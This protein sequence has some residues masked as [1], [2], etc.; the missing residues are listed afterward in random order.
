[1]VYF[2]VEGEYVVLEAGED[3]GLES[4]ADHELLL[5]RGGLPGGGHK[6]GDDLGPPLEHLRLKFLKSLG[7]LFRKYRWAPQA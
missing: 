3:Q 6:L 7:S 5:E 1:M 4:D 2:A